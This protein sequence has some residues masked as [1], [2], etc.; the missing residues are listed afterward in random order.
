MNVSA[1][2]RVIDVWLLNLTLVRRHLVMLAG[3]RGNNLLR[4]RNRTGG[5]ADE[6]GKQTSPT[7]SVL[8]DYDKEQWRGDK[9]DECNPKN[10][11]AEWTNNWS[12]SI[13]WIPCL[14]AQ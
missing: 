2:R 14:A 5:D 10:P 7:S 11:S 1:V 13:N 9:C 3:D 12:H 8:E 4:S 6:G